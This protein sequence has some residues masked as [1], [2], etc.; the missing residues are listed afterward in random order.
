MGSSAETT[1]AGQQ[2]QAVVRGSSVNAHEHSGDEAAS[3]RAP[4]SA[5]NISPI[6]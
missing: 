1:G 5:L 6:T 3:G 2:D 4:K